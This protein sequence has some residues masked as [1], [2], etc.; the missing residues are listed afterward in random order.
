M[1][2]GQCHKLSAVESNTTAVNYTE[3]TT[4]VTTKCPSIDSETA[5]KSRAPSPSIIRPEGLWSKTASYVD[6][7]TATDYVLEKLLSFSP[8]LPE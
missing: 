3:T 8:M 2:E 6:V 5:T 4:A 1:K 7:L